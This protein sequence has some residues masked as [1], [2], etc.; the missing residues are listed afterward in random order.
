[1]RC[2]D[3]G[4]R[5]RA[6]HDGYLALVA[7]LLALGPAM[8]ASAAPS[9]SAL[10]EVLD[11][12]VLRVCTSG[13]YRPFSYTGGDRLYEGADIEM[14]QS[15]GQS[16]N[17]RVEFFQ[18]PW[19]D[20]VASIK[21]GQCDIAMG[22][23]SVSLERARDATYS[24]VYLKDGKTAIARC[25]SASQ[26]VDLASIDRSGVRVIVNPG[27]TNQRFVTSHIKNASVT[28]FPDNAVIFDEIAA[29]RADIMITDASEVR[30][31]VKRHPGVLCPVAA[32]EPFLYGEKAYLLPRGDQ[33]WLEYVNQWLHL[34]LENGNFAA[35]A[36]RWLD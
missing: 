34:Q 2:G 4:A 22:G 12:G 31:Q 3:H 17:V 27:G 16:L 18:T 1:M 28:T 33:V 32:K 30:Q 11:R 5:R 19:K 10:D 14:A 6:W 26:Y 15:L 21:G 8:S 35:I 29:R 13:D 23:I 7:A 20:L 36:K 24:L 25:D 9:R